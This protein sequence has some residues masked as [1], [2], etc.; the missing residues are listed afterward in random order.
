MADSDDTDA[1][2]APGEG[3][4]LFR[5]R[6]RDGE[7]ADG[8]EAGLEPERAPDASPAKAKRTRR[9]LPESTKRLLFII[10]GVLVLVGSVAGFYLTSDAFESRVPVLVAARDIEAGETVSAADF[11][12][13]L[14][15]T[16]SVPHIPWTA[17]VPLS[18]EGTVALQPIPLGGLVRYDMVALVDTVPEGDELVVEVPLDLS[19]VTE[20]V[21]EGDLVLLVDPGVAPLPGDP[22]RPR[23][24]VR[25]F[26]LTSFDG[27]MMRLILPAQEWA[28]WTDLLSEVGGV[29]MVKDLG[30]RADVA[31]T[32]ESLD[33]VW[34]SQWSE[35]AA[36][37]AMAAA[38]AAPEAGPGELEV[39]VALDA[40][41]VPTDVAAGDLVLLV[42]PGAAPL[43]NN[44]G[45]PRKVIGTLELE[46]FSGG[47]MR[48]FVGP[49]DWQYWRTLP[50]ELGAAPMIL[51]VPPG[52]DVEDMSGRL[53]AVWDEEWRRLLADATAPA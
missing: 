16:G 9:Q 37:T 51:P 3:R 38:M 39:I 27:S 14:I 7:P 13:E 43:G 12:S 44:E 30:P 33:A 24:V 21:T 23:Q 46:N 26:T 29:L 19:L 28:E 32:S 41:L 6:A 45:R 5:R 36:A 17:D 8:D 18:L 50:D 47:Q 40:S 4:A 11:G 20:E 22:G 25:E 31:A 42:D 48:L 49:E 15:V 2:A 52:T 34:Q 35:A 53:D 10:A 1:A